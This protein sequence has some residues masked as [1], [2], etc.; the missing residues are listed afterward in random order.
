M[1]CVLSSPYRQLVRVHKSH[2]LTVLYS[3]GVAGATSSF[4]TSPLDMAKLRLQVC[5]YTD[6]GCANNTY[7]LYIY[8]LIHCISCTSSARAEGGERSRGI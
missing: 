4:L 1:V 8:V 6:L 5:Y 7:A 3:A 2:V